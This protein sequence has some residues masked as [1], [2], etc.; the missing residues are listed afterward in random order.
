MLALV[1]AQHSIVRDGLVA[2]LEAS[3]EIDKIVQVEKAGPARD[4]VQVIQ[5]DITL[6]YN[7]TLTNDLMTLVAEL[8]EACACPLIAI[9]GSEED[10][11][12]A[13][14]YGADI[15]VLEGFPSAKL[16]THITTLLRQIQK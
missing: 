12:V 10:R 5:P 3:P 11:N 8:K 13:I 1:V 16:E 7:I 2:F 9:V 6:L 14:S 15:A 4:V